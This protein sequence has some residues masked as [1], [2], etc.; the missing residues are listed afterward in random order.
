MKN[1]C[2]IFLFLFLTNVIYSQADPHGWFRLYP[3]TKNYY[4]IYFTNSDNG[5]IVGDSGRIL[6]TKNGGSNWFIHSTPTT[7]TLTKIIFTSND[8]GYIFGRN[9]IAYKTINGGENWVTL[10]FGITLSADY[11]NFIN[12]NTGFVSGSTK[13]FLRTT[14]G[15]MTWDQIFLN[16]TSNINSIFFLN[17]NTGWITTRKI[18]GSNDSIYYGLYKT[19]NSGASWS[20][21]RYRDNGNTA[22]FENVYF[23]D[24]LKG[25]MAYNAGVKDNMYYTQT[26]DG[27]L[28]W[29]E[30]LLG[31][32]SSYN[33]YF[34]N[35]QTG[36]A[37]GGKMTIT[38]TT[39]GGNSWVR[40]PGGGTFCIFEDVFFVNTMTGYTVGCNYIY[41]S[42]TGGVLT[43]FSQSE[44]ILS[45]DFLLSQ[46]YPNPFNPVTSIEYNLSKAGA[47]EIKIYDASGKIIVVLVNEN[48]QSGKYTV[49]FDGTD[50][51]SGIYIYS[52]FVDGLLR[53]TKKMA[54]IK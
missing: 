48:L 33:F 4:S 9:S 5:F 29:S 43:G 15:G 39:D 27:G 40:T 2:F 25:Y 36:W 16:N 14:D 8:T 28:S 20:L 10:N 52:L 12:S 37:S 24:T 46:N 18:F 35:D 30:L 3:I 13:Y 21:V 1:F 31:P 19:V 22:W 23:F 32:N 11:G 17:A 6:R 26:T 38:K 47:V 41:K 7:D 45:A 50:L 54:I 49:K 53:D 34:I 44:E 51:A 42:T